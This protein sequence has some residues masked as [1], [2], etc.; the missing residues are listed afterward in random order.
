MWLILGS[1][2]TDEDVIEV[3]EE[4][5]VPRYLDEWPDY[6]LNEEERYV[7]TVTVETAEDST[8]G[9]LQQYSIKVETE[10]KSETDPGG[11]GAPEQP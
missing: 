4:H 2:P 1:V 6:P 9:D 10:P 5:L 3:T 8:T 7:V 11:P